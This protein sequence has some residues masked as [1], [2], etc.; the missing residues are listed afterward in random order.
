MSD[1]I[2]KDLQKLES[3]LAALESKRDR[4][5]AIVENPTMAEWIDDLEDSIDDQI[6]GLKVIEKKNLEKAQARIEA[7]EALIAGLMFAYV[8]D[9]AAKKNEIENFKK[10]TPL[11]LAT[12][13]EDAAK[14]PDAP[15]PT[16]R[17]VKPAGK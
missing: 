2:K 6:K 16:K 10:T 15:K 3:H 13:Q 17:K 7:T 1:V 8:D 9:V 14:A 11:F 4:M 5:A 12:R